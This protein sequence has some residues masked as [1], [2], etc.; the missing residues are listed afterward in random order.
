MPINGNKA[1]KFEKVD[2]GHVS[3]LPD[4]SSNL[5]IQEFSDVIRTYQ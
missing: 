4:F 3:K 2:S 1:K 5:Y